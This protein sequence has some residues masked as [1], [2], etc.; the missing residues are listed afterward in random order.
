M[1]PP[2]QTA[3]DEDIRRAIVER[4]TRDVKIAQKIGAAHRQ[5]FRERF[6]GQVEHCLRLTAERLQACLV[7][8]DGLDISHPRTWP[9]TSDDI[10]GLA[11]ALESLW[12]VHRDL[13]QE[14]RPGPTEHETPLD[15]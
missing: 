8:G 1:M 5:A 7:K 12:M 4:E 11:R 10:L 3:R 14:P 15:D 2:D 6:P 13:R 9:A